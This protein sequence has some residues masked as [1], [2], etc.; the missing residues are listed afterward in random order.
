MR[1]RKDIF[2]RLSPARAG[3]P[4][5][6]PFG[7]DATARDVAVMINAVL[8]ESGLTPNAIRKV[9]V[10]LLSVSRGTEPRHHQP[11]TEENSDD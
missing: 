8:A 1:V 11:H 4:L 9:A 6:A 10:A 2:A 3:G 7:D 5:P